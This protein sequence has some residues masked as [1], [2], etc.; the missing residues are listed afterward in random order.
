MFKPVEDLRMQRLAEKDK[1]S[2]ESQ[3]TIEATGDEDK[4]QLDKVQVDKMQ[5]DKKPLV[6][7]SEKR[8]KKGGVEKKKGKKNRREKKPFN[9]YGI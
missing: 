4:M 3:I 6:D 1:H 5:V 7:Q 2:M 8:K 9:F